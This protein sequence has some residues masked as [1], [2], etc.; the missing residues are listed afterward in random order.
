MVIPFGRQGSTTETLGEAY[1]IPTDPLA[2][3][4]GSVCPLPEN[5]TPAPGPRFVNL[6][7]RNF[8]NRTLLMKQ[9]ITVKYTYTC[10]HISL[11]QIIHTHTWKHSTLNTTAHCELIT[12]K[13]T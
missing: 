5:P 11:K 7:C 9:H 8:T 4:K 12:F 2:G 10:W 6:G 3:G 1:S 13:H